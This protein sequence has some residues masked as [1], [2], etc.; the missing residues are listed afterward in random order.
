MQVLKRLSKIPSLPGLNLLSPPH[1]HAPTEE[2]KESHLRAQRLAFKAVREIASFI[3][4]GWTEIQAAQMIDRYLNDAGVHSSFH[5]GFA[6]FGERSGFEG[7]RSYGDFMPSKRVIR[8]GEVYILDVAPI[9]QG[10]TSDIGFTSSLGENPEM[11]QAKKFLLRIREEIPS[12]FQ[13]GQTG[14]EIWKWIESEIEGHGYENAYRKYPFSVV[15]HRVHKVPEWSPRLKY[16]R[17]GWQSL[18]SIASRGVFGQLLNQNFEGDLKGLW[19]IEPH[20]S[21]KTFG[22]KF[23][24]ILVVTENEAYWLDSKPGWA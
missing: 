23:E 4:E 22:A 15:G 8:A 3:Q 21:A 14:G 17:F 6:W 20:L 24:E 10:Y 7:M 16:M 2:E 19:A 18:W 11:E 12:K 13:S 9:Y 5:H 1:N